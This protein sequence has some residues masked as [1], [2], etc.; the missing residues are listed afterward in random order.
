MEIQEWHQESVIEIE[1]SEKS[2]VIRKSS[3][4]IDAF[5]VDQ[6]ELTR[7]L[8]S[9]NSAGEVRLLCHGE[10]SSNKLAFQTDFV[11]GTSSVL[12]QFKFGS[13]SGLHEYC[14][15]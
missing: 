2:K 5:G 15:D 4:S 13:S 3:D 6:I 11:P 1:V 9:P 8:K 10:D 14:A 7:Q 12:S